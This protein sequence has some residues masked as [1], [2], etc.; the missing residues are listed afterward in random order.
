MHL[1]FGVGGPG[2]GG[3]GGVIEHL[4]VWFTAS[5]YTN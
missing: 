2:G 4:M 3:G 5:V 1:I